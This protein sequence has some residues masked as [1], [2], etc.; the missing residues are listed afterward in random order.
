VEW[1]EA[2][3]ITCKIRRGRGDLVRYELIHI[4]GILA[5]T[6]WSRQ[7][8][9]SSTSNVEALRICSGS[10]TS[11][12]H[13]VVRPRWYGDGRGQ[14]NFAGREPSSCLLLFLG[15]NAWRTPAVIGGD[16]QGVVCVD[17][18]NSG[19][20]VKGGRVL[21]PISWWSRAIDARILLQI[22]YLPILMN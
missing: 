18:C 7:D 22:L 10:S 5:S 2:S 14:R 17:F 19:V 8:G 9:G 4:R 16:T 6:I 20:F 12:V 11:R 1:G 21:F 13:Q 15:G 3:A